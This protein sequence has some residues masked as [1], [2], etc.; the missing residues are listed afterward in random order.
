MQ[1]FLENTENSSTSTDDTS[2]FK[3]INELKE[4]IQQLSQENF[5]LMQVINNL[6]GSIYWKNKEG[7]YLG[8]NH[9][10]KTVMKSHGGKSIDPTGK[11]DFD[12]FPLKIAQQYRENDLHVMEAEEEM[13]KEEVCPINNK[14]MTRLSF[15]KPLHDVAGKVI[16][17]VGNT[18]DITYL[19]EIE[20][21]LHEAKEQAESANKAKTAFMRN[22]SHDIRTPLAGTIGGAEL[23]LDR[24]ED[25][26]AKQIAVHIKDSITQLLKLI[27]EIIEVSSSELNMAQPIQNHFSV[28][29]LLRELK[30]MFA[31][32]LYEQKLF[33]KIEID[34]A[35]PHYVLGNNILLRRILLNLLGNAIKFTKIGG[36]I[37]AVKIANITKD[38]MILVFSVE[39]TGVG[40]PENEIAT[41]FDPFHQISASHNNRYVGSGL[42]LACVKEYVNQ[43]KGEIQVESFLN[44]GTR[45]D[46]FI[47]LL[48]SNKLVEETVEL[49]ISA[50][51]S[52]IDNKKYNVLLVEDNYLA[53]K[54]AERLL[55]QQNY[56]VWLA[57]TIEAA[58]EIV[59]QQHFDLIY[60]DLSLPDGD[61]TDLGRAIR[62]HKTNHNSATPIIALTAH[63]DKEIEDLCLETGMQSVLEKPLDSE[64]VITIHNQY[65]I[66]HKHR[67]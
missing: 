22:I 27:N 16:G 41:I 54:A 37:V 65:C 11:T 50:P 20:E 38:N 57:E 36:V 9:S 2:D 60:L 28:Q 24:S 1:D 49:V 59:E 23:I 64:K 56:T 31:P 8:N 33:L 6:P 55:Q 32:A 52:P 66:K 62:E 29:K 25:A 61:G 35:V 19:K 18:V 5:L 53:R 51:L 26:E 14:V 3:L 42:G 67:D 44:R 48:F 21:K 58:Q 30:Q 17:I 46:F 47:P 7:I 13:S 12:L 45:F 43:L 15:K 40:I 63:R 10:A 39:D 34:P 4:K